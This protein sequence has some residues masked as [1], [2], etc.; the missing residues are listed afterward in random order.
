MDVHRALAPTLCDRGRRGGDRAAARRE[1]FAGPAFPDAH[2][3]VVW[4]VDAHQLDVRALRE[5]T[6]SLDQRTEPEKLVAF[7]ITSHDRMRIPDRDRREL[8]VLAADVDRL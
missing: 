6:V 1:R 2:G 5:A 7:R 3:D 8:D 4:S